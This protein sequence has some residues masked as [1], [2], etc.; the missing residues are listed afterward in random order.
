MSQIDDF[1]NDSSP[2][3]P[4]TNSAAAP[5]KKATSEVDDFLSDAPSQA[6]GIT[7]MA[8]DM[9]AWGLKGAIGLVEAPVGVADIVTG[10]RVGKALENEGGAF[11]FRPKQARE[12][13]NDWH[14]EATKDAQRKFQEAEGIG[15]KFQTAIQNPSNIVGA[16]AESLPSMAGG[17]VAARGLLGATRLGQAGAK[18]T[19]AAEAAGLSAQASRAAGAAASQRAATIAGA[20]GEGT[21]MAGSQ[22][23]AIRQE[24]PD[25]LLTPAQAGIAAATGGIGGLIGGA[26][27]RLANKLGVGDA[28]TMLAQGAKGIARQ[29]AD[30][31]ATAAA[32]PLVQQQAK[33]VPRQ[34]IEGAITEGLLEELP[35]SVAEPAHTS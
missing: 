13:A 30:E 24:T 20:A 34:V 2:A 5:A 19:A 23:E 8:R 26:S 28:D 7:G 18:A 11:G 6:R 9:A 32:N 27:G 4:V 21:M 15:G 29:N 10:G 12:A 22:A 3:A 1:L 14:S 25:G 16:V 33:S 17:A 31:A 35:Q